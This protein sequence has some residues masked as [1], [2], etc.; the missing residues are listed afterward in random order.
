LASPQTPKIA[1]ALLCC[2]RLDPASTIYTTPMS[3]P[4]SFQQNHVVFSCPSSLAKLSQPAS[5]L[6][7]RRRQREGRRLSC[8]PSIPCILI[9]ADSCSSWRRTSS[10]RV[11]TRWLFMI[12]RRLDLLS[13]H[14]HAMA[15]ANTMPAAVEDFTMRSTSEVIQKPVPGSLPLR[16]SCCKTRRRARSN[17]TV[18]AIQVQS[19]AAVVNR[20]CM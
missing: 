2:A 13:E 16:P 1:S 5:P 14:V 19:A 3:R 18:D 8:R 9:S 15:E 17:R 7:Y 20:P 11:S 6:D 4:L 12:C 10:P